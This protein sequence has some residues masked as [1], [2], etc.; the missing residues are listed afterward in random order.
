VD[1]TDFSQVAFWRRDFA[2]AGLGALMNALAVARNAVLVPR[3]LLAQHAL[4]VGDMIRVTV[5]PSDLQADLDLQIAGYFTY[6][7]SW[8]P[9]EGLLFVGNLDYLFEKAGGN[10][11]FDL[12]LKTDPT[13]DYAQIVAGIEQLGPRVGFWQA[14][15]LGIE[16]E[17]LRPERQGVF[18]LLSVGFGAAA[19]LTVL[20]FLLYAIFSF[21]RRFIELGILRAIGLSH[22]QMTV[23]LASELALLI[24][25]GLIVGTAL[26]AW[27][28]FLFIPYLQVGTGP[29]SYIPPFLVEIAWPAI[30]RIYV[31]F[32]SLFLVTLGILA[33]LL[34]R[35][36]IFQAIKLGESA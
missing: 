27:V 36:R 33:A 22:G 28:S 34:L 13:P 15:A 10:A 19:I 6:F 1:R 5:A 35:M 26:G 7:P 11:L 14:S 21:R 30:I 17:Q 29:A 25:I 23:L 8:Y 3:D 2:P 18:G 12:W 24:L 31:L 32:G 9:E 20:G 16:R 4:R